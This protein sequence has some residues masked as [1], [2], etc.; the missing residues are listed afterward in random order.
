MKTLV[1]KYPE[2]EDVLEVSLNFWNSFAG[3]PGE[4][5]SDCIINFFF[6]NTFS[7]VQEKSD[8]IW[9]YERYSLVIEYHN[10][11]G[12][13]PPFILLSHIWLFL[14]YIH[15]KYTSKENKSPQNLRTFNFLSFSYMY[16]CFFSG[17]DG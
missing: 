14:Q 17:L 4:T 6:S 7:D 3:H 12:L 9:K 5:A 1:V 8:Q 11:S 16:V 2:T 13:V 10:R 15:R